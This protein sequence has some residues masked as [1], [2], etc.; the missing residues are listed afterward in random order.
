MKKF[1]GISLAALLIICGG[2]AFEEPRQLPSSSQ[3]VRDD[4]LLGRTTIAEIRK[5]YEEGKYDSFLKKMDDFYEKVSQDHRLEE[6]SSL[7]E[8]ISINSEWGAFVKELQKERN[9]Q[10]IQAVSGDESLFGEKVRS[11]ASDISSESET[12]AFLVL[13]NIHQMPLD[14]GTNK[15]ENALISIDVEYE[16]K[17]LHLGSGANHDIDPRTGQYVLKMQQLDKMLLASES[18]EDAELKEVVL[19]AS[20]NADVRMAQNWDSLDLNALVQGKFKPEGR[21]QEKVVS[22]LQ[23]YQEKL[24]DG[25]SQRVNH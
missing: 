5:N 11:S 23:L 19:L 4:L 16:C 7:R 22:V 9:Q 10:L 17:S 24:S 6:F 8:G 1:I 14:S 3:E 2:F 15:D 20:Q 18:F 13:A 21:F 25:Y 12:Q